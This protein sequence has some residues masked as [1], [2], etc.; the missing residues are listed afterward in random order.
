MK[1]Y[2][3]ISL[4]KIEGKALI[5]RQIEA[6]KATFKNFE[7]ILCSGFETY[8]TVEF[9]R[10]NFNDINIRVVENQIHFNSNCCES[11]RLCLHNTNNDKVLLCNGALLLTPDIL[12]S[13]NYQKSTLLYQKE[14]DD[15][16]FDVGIIENDGILES[17]SVGIK[18]KLWS[19][20]IYF[21]NKK[22]INSFYNIVSNPDYKNRFLFEAINMVLKNNKIFVNKI[23]D[24]PPIKIQ[25]IKTLK[26]IT[27]I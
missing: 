25:N 24:Y 19:E 23:D 16:N 4:M 15:K 27:K 8:K 18:G 11:A 3:P 13:I 22:V 6:I 20:I 2:G 5:Q 14:D 1:S 9:I 10:N 7:I 26:R 21:S 12:S 17:M